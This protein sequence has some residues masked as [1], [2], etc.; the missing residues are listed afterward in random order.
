MLDCFNLER[1]S[2]FKVRF[3]GGGGG[4]V[5]HER[6]RPELLGGGGGG[7]RLP[8][9]ILNY[10]VSMASQSSE[11]INFQQFFFVEAKNK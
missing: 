3:I 6:R 10:R 5:N 2:I 9:K 11:S 7:G 4:G 8:P 1:K